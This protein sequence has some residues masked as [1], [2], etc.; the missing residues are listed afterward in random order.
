VTFVTPGLPQALSVCEFQEIFKSSATQALAISLFG[1]PA[2]SHPCG[3]A[4]FQGRAGN[5]KIHVAI[6]K[7]V[8]RH[9]ATDSD[10]PWRSRKA[11]PKWRNT[12]ATFSR[13][14]ST[15]GTRPST[16]FARMWLL[17]S[18]V[19]ARGFSYALEAAR[20]VLPGSYIAQMRRQ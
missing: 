15:S 3:Q 9:R 5:T 13:L 18:K 14:P 16:P 7:V 11:G 1:W 8:A 19:M 17:Q 6:A 4:P 2:T 20:S 10:A 12:S